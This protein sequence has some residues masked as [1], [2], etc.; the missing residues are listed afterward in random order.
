MSGLSGVAQ[1]S[2]TKAFNVP[3][4]SG[5]TPTPGCPQSPAYTAPRTHVTSNDPGN[6]QLAPHGAHGGGMVWEYIVGHTS[7]MR[8]AY[9]IVVAFAFA[10]LM[11]LTATPVVEGI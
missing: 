2:A 11:L 9:S 5:H 10:A 3:A 6:T 8:R 7:G 4:P 1:V